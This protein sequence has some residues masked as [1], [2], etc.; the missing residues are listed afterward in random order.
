MR[1]MLKHRPHRGVASNLSALAICLVIGAGPPSWGRKPGPGSIEGLT[2]E[3]FSLLRGAHL[4]VHEATCLERDR[5]D[6][7]E[8][9]STARDAGSAARR[10][11]AETLVLVHFLEATI[12]DPGAVSREAGEVFDGSIVVGEDL[13]RYQV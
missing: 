11:G 2:T 10:A 1:T 3:L 6:G 12:A 13:G 4:L 8:G 9:H 5:E 7:V